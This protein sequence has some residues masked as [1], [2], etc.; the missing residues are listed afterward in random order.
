MTDELGG[1]FGA[2]VGVGLGLYTLK[3][4][5]N[6]SPEHRTQIEELLSKSKKV[7][8]GFL[9]RTRIARVKEAKALINRSGFKVIEE[10]PS[11]MDLVYIKFVEKNK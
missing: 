4:L 2:I 10:Y 7:S 8:N 11:A 5:S 6:L 9:L 1:L 3:F